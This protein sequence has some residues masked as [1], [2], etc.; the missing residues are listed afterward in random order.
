MAIVDEADAFLFSNFKEHK[1]LLKKA[2]HQRDVAGSML[3]I[4]SFI[5]SYMFI[6]RQKS[7]RTFGVFSL[8]VCVLQSQNNVI[9]YVC[10]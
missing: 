5:Y 10:R 3:F 9:N 4:H 6:H 1:Q 7:T 2:H 8:G